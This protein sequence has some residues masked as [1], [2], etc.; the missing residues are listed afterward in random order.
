MLMQGQ[1]Q[2]IVWAR[3]DQRVP[4]RER[5]LRQRPS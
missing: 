3:T 4:R 2:A 1:V 5:R